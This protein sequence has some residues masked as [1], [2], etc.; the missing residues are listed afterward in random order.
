MIPLR[1]GYTC[2]GTLTNNTNIGGRIESMNIW[3]K[4]L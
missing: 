4:P 3:H 2:A 1:C